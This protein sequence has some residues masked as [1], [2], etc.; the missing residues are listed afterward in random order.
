M[1]AGSEQDQWIET[2]TDIKMS[3]E[4][5]KLKIKE[6]TPQLYMKSD[7]DFNFIDKLTVREQDKEAFKHNR[8]LLPSGGADG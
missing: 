8:T 2:K 1:H 7:I 6:L 4:G 3:I 5:I